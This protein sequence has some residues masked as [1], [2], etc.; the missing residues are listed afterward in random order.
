[1]QDADA[2]SYLQQI[3]I[4]G[5]RAIDLIQQ[6]LTFSRQ[7]YQEKMEIS[8]S[9][10]FHQ[11]VS[12]LNVSLPQ[13]ITLW[14]MIDDNVATA[15]VNNVQMH[16]VMQNLYDNAVYAMRERGG[17]LEIRLDTVQVDDAMAAQYV[18]LQ[19]GPYACLVTRDTGEGMSAEVLDHIF[20]PFFT[21]K[22]VGK[23]IGMGL[24]VVHGIVQS[25]HGAI[26]V[27]SSPGEGSTFTIYLPLVVRES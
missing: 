2:P 4:A 7:D 9:L 6:M 13:N 1:M 18:N 5:Q 21:T 23:G 3:S 20:E 12:L 25:H 27:Q 17:I 10:L 19:K 14:Q 15:M 24:A 26:A 11:I 22:D 16:Q 8:L